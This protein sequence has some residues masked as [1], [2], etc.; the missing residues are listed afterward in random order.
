MLLTGISEANQRFEE[1]QSEL[2][3]TDQDDLLAVAER[4]L[5]FEIF[6]AKKKNG[7]PKEDEPSKLS[8][9]STFSVGKPADF[10]SFGSL[11]PSSTNSSI[12][13]A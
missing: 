11:M 8:F 13:I 3:F 6:Q 9:I 5:I 2:R 10:F 12:S 1:M 4:D 7:M